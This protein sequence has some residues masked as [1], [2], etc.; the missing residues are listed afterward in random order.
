MTVSIDPA[1]NVLTLEV[2]RSGSAGSSVC[3]ADSGLRTVAAVSREDEDLLDIRGR[4]WVCAA[5]TVL[6]TILAL[7]LRISGLAFDGPVSRTVAEF[8]AMALA[9]PVVLWGAWPLLVGGW[10]ST[11]TGKPTIFA[12][13][14][15]TVAA[16]YVYGVTATLF[17]ETL[18]T[19]SRFSTGQPGVYFSVA[20]VITLF[21]LLGRFLELDAGNRMSMAIRALKTG[22]YANPDHGGQ[23]LPTPRT[24]LVVVAARRRRTSLQALPDTA[25]VVLVAAAALAAAATFIVWSIWGPEP[26]MAFA[27]VN[28]LGVL[29]IACPC[30]LSLAKP[31]SLAV[32]GA[33]A[34]DAGILFESAA[35]IEAMQK[36]DTLVIGKT[37]A[38]TEGCPR[39]IAVAPSATSSDSE[40]LR[41]AASLEQASENPLASAIVAGARERGLELTDAGGF[42]SIP[43]MGVHGTVGKN[44]VVVGNQSLVESRAAL[45]ENAVTRADQLCA[46]G[47]TVMFVAVDGVVVGLLGVVDSVKKD[48]PEAIGQLRAEGIQV[49]LVT[50]DRQATADAIARPLGI[51]HVEAEV[52]SDQKADV[53]R[54]IQDEGKTVAVA[55]DGI[56]DAAAFA[57]ADV[58]IE[59]GDVAEGT[60]RSDG[61]HL[62][63]GGLRRVVWARRLSRDT[64]S[65][66]RQNTR[67]ALIFS[68]LGLPIA[69]GVLFPVFGWLL[70]PMIAVAAMS[71]SSLSVIGNALRLQ[72]RDPAAS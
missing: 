63:K 17:P 49:V 45:P 41:L 43:G 71:L 3:G 56:N 59:L 5:F 38:L 52:R 27:F 12:L 54:R 28:T 2:P 35:A 55:G 31:I 1:M 58:G 72:R 69:A 47:L 42:E 30:G 48:I 8:L 22:R 16:A 44:S 70:S 60:T 40:F 53:V 39:L 13:V 6:L 37:G 20:A 51:D 11:A 68:S 18:P 23:S 7:S 36:V 29:I 10:R 9:T 66:I 25:T 62:T 33:K 57:Q 15:V 67:F 61:V 65:T 21:A 50:G 64:T 4:F 32:A 26:A 34:A 46:D 14:G 24:R 19:S